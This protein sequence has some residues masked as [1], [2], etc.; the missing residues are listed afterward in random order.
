MD[1]DY[2]EELNELRAEWEKD[3][4]TERQEEKQDDL[5]QYLAEK[6]EEWLEEE[7]QTPEAQQ[8]LLDFLKERE[9][10]YWAEQAKEN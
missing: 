3:F 4:W 1:S 2:R 5:N 6:T 7:R 10:E 9:R 8:E